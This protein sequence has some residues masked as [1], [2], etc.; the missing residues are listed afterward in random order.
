MIFKEDKRESYVYILFRPNGIPCYVGKGIAD[1]WLVHEKKARNPHLAAIIAKAGGS[2]PRVKIR[3]GLTDA[4]ACETEIAFIAAIG[5]KVNG[6]PLVNMTDGGD[7]VRGST[8]TK[9]AE[10]RA[11]ISAAHKG[12]K[13][14]PERIAEMSARQLGKPSPRKGAKLSEQTKAKVSATLKAKGIIPPSRA[15][16]ISS[17]ESNAKRSA[18]LKAHWANRSSAV[19]S[20]VVRQ[21]VQLNLDIA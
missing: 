11:K 13:F 3:E 9:S 8:H 1:R 2:I 6:G 20:P 18:A 19:A 4:E 14:S 10:A 21:P 17:P 5:R 15:G 16:S 12:R 7:G